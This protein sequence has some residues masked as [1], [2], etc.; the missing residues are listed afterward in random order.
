MKNLKLI[1]DVESLSYNPKNKHFYGDICFDL[2]GIYYPDKNW[3]DYILTVLLSWTYNIANQKEG[4]LYFFDGPYEI[5]FKKREDILCLFIE[6]LGEYHCEIK[7]L[8]QMIRDDLM[9]IYNMEKY[10]QVLDKKKIMLGMK[11]IDNY[12]MRASK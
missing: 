8:L 11:T 3:N 6:S 2:D 10:S 12:F 7:Y 1:F 4:T 5:S 9:K